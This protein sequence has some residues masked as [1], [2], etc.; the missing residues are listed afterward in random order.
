[1]ASPPQFLKTIT[2]GI[3]QSTL[4]PAKQVDFKVSLN[5]TGNDIT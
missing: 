1:M 3:A 2:T 5:Y 4:P